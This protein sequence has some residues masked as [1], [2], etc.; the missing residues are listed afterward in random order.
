MS[1]VI[2]KTVAEAT[3]IAIH[4]MAKTQAWRVP[5]AA[6]PKLGSP[7]LQH[8]SFHWEAPDKYTKW[9]AFIL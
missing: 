8:P 4:T 6:V 1:E 9:K 2:T 3:K 5:N 7:T